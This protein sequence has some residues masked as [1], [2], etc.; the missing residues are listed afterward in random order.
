MIPTL[1]RAVASLVMAAVTA[2]VTEAAIPAT[3]AAKPK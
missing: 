2:S 1:A 3:G